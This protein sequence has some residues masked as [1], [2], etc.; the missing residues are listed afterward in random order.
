MLRRGRVQHGDVV[1][2][3]WIHGS[4]PLPLR[5][6]TETNF[7]LSYVHGDNSEQNLF[8]RKRAGVPDEPFSPF[9]D[10]HGGSLESNPLR[11][12]G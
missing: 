5:I 2:D 12:N 1:E 6:L 4:N 9:N 8:V 10:L 11:R 3:Y 7:V